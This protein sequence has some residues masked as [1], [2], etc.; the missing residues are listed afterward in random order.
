MP[1]ERP[2]EEQAVG[3]GLPPRSFLLTEGSKPHPQ[4]HTSKIQHC[5]TRANIHTRTAWVKG[6]LGSGTGTPNPQSL[7]H[8][9]LGS[10]GQTGLQ[11][12]RFREFC[13]SISVSL[14]QFLYLA[15]SGS[16]YCNKILN[17]IKPFLSFKVNNS[18][19]QSQCS[20]VLP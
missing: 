11:G 17:S 1:G 3:K 7:P 10:Q 12:V 13:P 2:N 14:C 4:T 18:L 6:V 15:L 19:E 5:Q 8:Q 9:Q 20:L 16:F